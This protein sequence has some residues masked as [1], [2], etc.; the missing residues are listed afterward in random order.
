MLFFYNIIKI[1]I[2]LGKIIFVINSVSRDIIQPNNSIEHT[3]GVW[4][5]VIKNEMPHKTR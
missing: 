4:A 1:V 2:N 3:Q 5:R